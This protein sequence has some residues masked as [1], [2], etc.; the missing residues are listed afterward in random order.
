VDFK[1]KCNYCQEPI[2]DNGNGL[3]GKQ[4]RGLMEVFK[5]VARARE[6]ENRPYASAFGVAYLLFRFIAKLIVY[7][8]EANY[9]VL[10]SVFIVN[11]TIRFF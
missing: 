6:E 10:R 9:L 7:L 4:I 1:W 8:I 2:F 11:P 3:P 5:G